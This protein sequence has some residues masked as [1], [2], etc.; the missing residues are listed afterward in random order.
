MWWVCQI[1]AREHYAIP[2]ALEARGEL[3]G[4]CT[5]FWLPPGHVLG[6]FPGARRLRDRYHP[7]LAT[8][9]VCAPNARMLAF[10]LRQRIAKK[11]GWEPILA[12]N[13]LFQQLAFA[14]LDALTTDNRQ[15]T[16]LFS[17]SYAARDLF[18]FAKAR[19]WRTVLGQIDPGPEEERIVEAEHERYRH[20]ASGWRPAPTRYWEW[21]REEIALADRVLVNS[22][23]SRQCLLQ[24]NVPAE[25]VEVV[26]L[27]Y[28]KVM[29]D[30]SS[31]ISA[32]KTEDQGQRTQ[33]APQAQKQI[34]L[35]LG[36][37]NLRKGMG[38]LLDAMRLLKNDPIE[39]ILAGPTELS[40]SAWADLPAVR[41]IGGIPRSEVDAVYRSADLFILPTLS[42]GYALTQL[43]ALARGLPVMAS[44]YCGRAVIDGR[45]GW[46]LEN[47]EPHR[48]AD[49]LRKVMHGKI[50]DSVTGPSFSMEDLA[51]A[52]LR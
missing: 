25:K 6:R 12:R 32:R 10:E 27:V 21:W 34:L 15:P 31:V 8:S 41:W 18:K 33:H 16:T 52:L 23:W 28:G 22:E 35:F 4:L 24:E 47:L 29:S 42:D 26:P 30:Q 20:L 39:L 11:S 40:P 37:I 51:A 1:G 46:V 9:Q 45:N 5:D 50:P 49:A 13:Q 3:A 7:D 14:K 2:R 17:Y 36:Q 38:R 19:G 48:I 43:E 44:R